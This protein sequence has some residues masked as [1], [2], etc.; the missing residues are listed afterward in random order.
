M[1]KNNFIF[2]LTVFVIFIGCFAAYFTFQAADMTK[3]QSGI[4]LSFAADSGDI[5]PFSVDKFKNMRKFSVF[6]LTADTSTNRLLLEQARQKLNF[7][8]QNADTING[9]HFIMADNTSY[10]DY[11]KTVDIC[12]EKEPH[13]FA[14]YQNDIYAM[15]IRTSKWATVIKRD[16]E[17]N[18]SIIQENTKKNEHYL[19]CQGVIEVKKN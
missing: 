14:P 12:R 4:L 18:D 1:T 16:R 11:I 15:F 10:N 5:S 6:K 2:L 9:I 8:K 17:K 7:I 19:R 3:K 13:M